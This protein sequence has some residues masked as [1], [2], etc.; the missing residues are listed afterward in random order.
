M[1]L[2]EKILGIFLAKKELS[3]EG[4]IARAEKKFSGMDLVNEILRIEGI[5]ERD[6]RFW[7][8]LVDL[9][10]KYQVDLTIPCSEGGHC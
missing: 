1:K 6:E 3:R 7:Y 10:A 2:I 8:R 5:D 9:C 4:K